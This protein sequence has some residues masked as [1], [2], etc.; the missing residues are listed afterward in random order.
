MAGADLPSRAIREQIGSAVNIVVQQSRMRDGTR[1][2]V[3]IAEILGTTGDQVN[4]QEI[5]AFR[6][7]GVD[8]DG[9]VKGYF[10]ATGV[11]PHFLEYMV[12][13]GEGLPEDI[14]QVTPQAELEVVTDPDSDTTEAAI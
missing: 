3:S 10:T 6:Q 7:T 13:S 12:Q 4:L 11:I 9:N 8:E 1:K 14:F 5:F 2:V